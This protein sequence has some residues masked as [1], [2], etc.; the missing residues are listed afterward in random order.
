MNL[1]FT[2]PATK[3]ARRRLVPHTLP[4]RLQNEIND[5]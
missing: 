4:L 5:A 3:R 1:S 2:F